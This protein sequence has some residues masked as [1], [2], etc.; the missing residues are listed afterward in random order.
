[1]SANT[2][3]RDLKIVILGAGPAGLG[4]AYQLARQGLAQVTVLERNSLMGGNTGSFELAG[5]HVDYGSHRLHPACDPEVLGDIRT[6]LGAD[7]LDRPRHGRIR[8]RGRWIHFPLKPVDLALKLPPAFA[9]GVATD[10]LR[11]LARRNGT[12]PGQVESFATVLEAGL[13]RTICRD[14]YFPYAQKIW[15]VAP[16][17]LSAI[18]ARRRVSAGSLTK[19]V[20]K[21]LAAVPGLKPAGSGRFFYPRRGFGQIA[22]AYG[23]AALAAGAQIHLNATVEAIELN[24]NGHHCV[25]YTQQGQTQQITADHVWSTIPA[26][27]LANLLRP[28]AP[29]TLLAAAS[30]ITYRAMLLIYLVVGQDQFSEFDAHYFPEAHI[31]ITRLSEPKNYSNTR[32]PRGHTVLCAELPCSPTDRVWSQSEAELGMLV[33]QALAASELP[34]QAP[35]Q[36]VVVRRLPQAYPIYQDGYEVP[37]TQLDQWLDQQAGLLSYGRQGLFAHDNTHHALYMAYAAVN[38][39]EADGCFNRERWHDYRKIFAT[40]VVED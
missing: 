38:C 11:K 13:G 22:D 8:L 29:P 4:A 9:V 2:P 35:V 1:M 14:F 19:M 40:H 36:Q 39:L 3:Q 28:A 34:L 20:R 25:T 32:E 5:I 21:V 17:T 15:G 27:V 23:Q 26:P 37:F 31:P 12:Q 18:Q 33:Q 7:L 10:S 30:Q 24:A 16:N 6:L